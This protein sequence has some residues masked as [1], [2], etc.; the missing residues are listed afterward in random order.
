MPRRGKV[1]KRKIVPDPIYGSV[2][3]QRFIN[4]MMTEGKK[5]KAERIVYT[6][7]QVS[8][9]RLKKPP[10]EVFE[11]AL[12]NISPFMEVKPRRVGGS[13]YQVPIEVPPERG[14]ALAMK[15]VRDFS[16]ARAGKSIIE[17]LS[18]ELVDAYNNAGAAI[19]KREDTHKMAEANK[20]FAHFRW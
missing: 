16:R 12:K 9:D 20:A 4:K 2:K 5:S 3:V 15:W 10:L 17:K 14:E 8:A 18:A 1:P 7:I 19:K 6:A 11:K 13:T